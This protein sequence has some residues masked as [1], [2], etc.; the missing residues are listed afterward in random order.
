M[1]EHDVQNQQDI[2]FPEFLG[3][4][5]EIVHVAKPIVDLQ[6]IADRI[7]AVAFACRAHQNRHDM[8]HV[9]AQFLKIRYFVSQI[10]QAV[11]ETVG[12]KRDV[13]QLVEFRP[14]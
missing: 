12:I 4:L 14:L 13:T 10:S 5:A 3:N 2:A 6:E 11:R 8:H 7:A 1:I 9:D